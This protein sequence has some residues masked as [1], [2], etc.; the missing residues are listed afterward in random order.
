MSGKTL[1]VV[2]HTQSIHHVEGRVGGWYDTGLTQKGRNDAGL[3]AARLAPLIDDGK[4]ELFSSD[5]LRASQTADIIGERLGLQPVLMKDLRE[6]SYGV[7]EGQPEAWM[8]GRQLPPPDDNRL[9]HRGGID[10]GETR[11]E[12]AHRVY[13]AMDE[14][15]A[16]PC[17]TQIVVTHGFALTFVVAHWIKM[18]IEAAG[19]IALR[20]VSGSIT[21]LAQDA[22]WNNRAVITLAGSAHLGQTP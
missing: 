7:A 17:T 13:R 19:H 6:M 4:A 16:R 21:H 9:D 8:Q 1:Y 12:L 3:V 22:F 5:L 18:P 2:T 15:L 10:N 20:A 11:R 14:I